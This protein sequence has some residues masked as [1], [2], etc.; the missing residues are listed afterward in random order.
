MINVDDREAPSIVHYLEATDE[1]GRAVLERARAAMGA[2]VRRTMLT[3]LHPKDRAWLIRATDEQ[4]RNNKMI[5][6]PKLFD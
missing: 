6:Q 4:L 1:A 5:A 2:P 3:D